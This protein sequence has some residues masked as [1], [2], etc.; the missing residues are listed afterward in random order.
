[1]RYSW[2]PFLTEFRFIFTCPLRQDHRSGVSPSRPTVQSVALWVHA[3]TSIACHTLRSHRTGLGLLATRGFSLRNGSAVTGK[4]I[5]PIATFSHTD[6]CHPTGSSGYSLP[7]FA[8]TPHSHH[9]L[10]NPPGQS[11]TTAEPVMRLNSI[12]SLKG[13]VQGITGDIIACLMF[14]KW[15]AT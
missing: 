15:L 8:S 13:G 4:K 9:C 6:T 10:H 7:T 3:K 2:S 11:G 5:S 12:I 1:M 14:V